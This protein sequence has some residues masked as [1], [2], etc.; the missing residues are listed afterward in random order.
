[1][2]RDIPPSGYETHFYGEDR[3]PVPRW[4]YAKGC[5]AASNYLTA[6]E[7]ERRAPEQGKHALN[8]HMPT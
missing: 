7:N 5:N 6:Y 1:M 2:I 8:E 3:G 4:G